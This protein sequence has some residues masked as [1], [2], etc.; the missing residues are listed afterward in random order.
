MI[1]ELKHAPIAIP[2]ARQKA[3]SQYQATLRNYL[4][5]RGQGN[6]QFADL[7]PP[8]TT[9]IPG[10]F[11][12]FVMRELEDTPTRVILGESQGVLD[13]ESR[14]VLLDFTSGHYYRS[15][16]P[17]GPR[18]FLERTIDAKTMRG[19]ERELSEETI[20]GMADLLAFLRFRWQSPVQPAKR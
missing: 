2:E 15:N 3:V 10:A 14:S 13:T 18:L 7:T 20:I 8:S 9:P 12:D 4:A 6:G 19:K 5:T 17:L 1:P 11:Q 16:H